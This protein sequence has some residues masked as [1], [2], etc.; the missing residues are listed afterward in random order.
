[1]HPIRELPR[2]FATE[3]CSTS[4]L[5]PDCASRNSSAS[6]WISSISLRSPASMCWER[7]GANA[8]LPLW[9]EMT[10]ALKAWLACRPSRGASELFLNGVG[11]A[12]TRSGFEYILAKHVA[13]AAHRQ[14]SIPNKRVSPHV[15]RPTCAMHTLQATRDVRKVSLWLGN[16]RLQSTEIYLRADPTEKLEALAVTSAPMFKPGRFRAPDK[17]IAMLNSVG[18]PENYVK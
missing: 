8:Y 12:M 16:A 4:P 6:N 14:P 3:P 11:R 2:A 1:M 15:L 17:L 10:A 7:G 18:Q 13:S 5:Q 9:K